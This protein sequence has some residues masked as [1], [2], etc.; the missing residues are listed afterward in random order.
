MSKPIKRTESA[1]GTAGYQKTTVEI[2]TAA[3]RSAQ[4]ALHTRGIKETVNAALRTVSRRQDLR[5]AADY[6]L[7]GELHG[8]DEET[9]A[10]WREP[11]A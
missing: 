8:P 2:D 9:W 7:A 3:L 6:V 5:A 1:T 10:A 4:T 11:R